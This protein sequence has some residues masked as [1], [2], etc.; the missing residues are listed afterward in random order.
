[1]FL[2]GLVSMMEKSGGLFGFTKDF[3]VYATTCRSGQAVSFA[4][5]CFIFFDDCEIPP[6]AVVFF[7]GFPQRFF[8][9][10][11]SV[12][13]L[14]LSLSLSLNS[15]SPPHLLLSLSLFLP[16]PSSSSP[17]PHPDT[18][19]LLAGESMKP[20][21][22]MLFVS[23]EK[24]SFIVDAT[25]APIASLTPISSWVGFETG[26][27]QDELD[28]IIAN[29][30]G[31]ELEIET[32]GIG[33][34]LETIQ[35]RYYPIFMLIFIPLMIGLQRDF[36]PMLIAE[37]KTQVY[38]RTDG[39]DNA[40]MNKKD[41]PDGTVVPKENQP[42]K[43]VP[44]K[45]WNMIAPV[46]ILT[47]FVIYFLEETGRDEEN[48]RNFMDK[49]N[50]SDSYAALLWGTF[51]TALLTM[52]MY[53]LQFKQE[54]EWML[55]TPQVLQDA[56][57]GYVAYKM[58][59]TGDTIA[60]YPKPLMSIFEGL[61]SFFYGFGRVFPAIVVLCLAW[62]VGA[63]MADVGADRL[64]S[65]WIV[66][67]GI[68]YKMLPTLS[69]LISFF[70]ALATGTS[71][72]TM[73]IVFPLLLVPTFKSCGGDARVFYATVA[74]V[75]SGSVAG[76]HVSPIS[77]TT[78][79]SALACDCNLLAH[80]QTQSPIAMVVIALSIV[81]GTLPVGYDMMPNAINLILGIIVLV[82][83]VMV[84]CQPVIS[85]TGNFDFFTELFMK[86]K[87]AESPLLKLKA[88]TI[89]KF[90]EGHEG[91]PKAAAVSAV[92]TEI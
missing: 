36:G 85:P 74:G 39:G 84:Y 10:S 80:V 11:L 68:S 53:L 18:N 88:D 9:L 42:E 45:S 34:F 29:N 91:P 21:L 44:L 89:K 64:F 78:V 58:S 16:L 65:S 56:V 2:S 67:S 3:A 4:I 12:S 25:A 7:P 76:D 35:Y 13:F 87:G 20:L 92:A 26:L 19:I 30:P 90:E 57:K 37:R 46:F 52:L 40:G 23:R 61:E 51:V 82:G 22:D 62:A 72:G 41:V 38:N 79:L 70:I 66:D 5:G 75:L 24:L 1:M 43:D 71:W 63:V 8:L 27:I 15:S 14:S 86:S 50:N 31:V 73:T 83:F 28:K 55:A 47:F 32:T 17:P 33:V 6:F 48:K 59:K 77:D 69:F 60:P 49:L 54:G 81:F